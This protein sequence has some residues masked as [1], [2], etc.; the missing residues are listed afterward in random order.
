M[1]FKV[2]PWPTIDLIIPSDWTGTLE[3]INPGNSA[4]QVNN[5][6]TKESQLAAP[7]IVVPFNSRSTVLG[8]LNTIVDKPSVVSVPN[9]KISASDALS[10]VYFLGVRG[11]TFK[12][13]SV[14]AITGMF[15]GRAISFAKSSS[16]SIS[17]PQGDVVLN[18]QN[19]ISTDLVSLYS[20]TAPVVLDVFPIQQP[21]AG[22][23]FNITLMIMN[24]RN[25]D[26]N[27]DLF[28]TLKEISPA[29]PIQACKWVS[30]EGFD[31]SY[32]RSFSSFLNNFNSLGYSTPLEYKFSCSTRFFE[33][34]TDPFV[35]NIVLHYFAG[36]IPLPYVFQLNVGIINSVVT[37]SN[38]FVTATNTSALPI[39]SA[40]PNH[41]C[42]VGA[43]APNSQ[44]TVTTSGFK[45]SSETTVIDANRTI[46]M[47]LSSSVDPQLPMTKFSCRAAR[48]LSVGSYPYSNGNVPSPQT[49]LGCKPD[50]KPFKPQI[51]HSKYTLNLRL[52]R[53][54]SDNVS[55]LHGIHLSKLYCKQRQTSRSVSRSQNFR[56][57]PT[58]HRL[59]CTTS[60]KRHFRLPHNQR[61]WIWGKSP[62][63]QFR[64]V[65]LSVIHL[66]CF[67]ASS[68][69]R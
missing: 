39:P 45:P 69:L 41:L 52:N 16:V 8:R 10:P 20:A 42:A 26:T 56:S 19:P 51:L 18:T 68:S 35:Y 4:L 57:R 50:H 32:I 60:S 9:L 15:I 66:C 22:S 44:N 59:F 6:E 64:I 25:L 21:A 46:L 1:C 2:Y 48:S 11:G 24:V 13:I 67:R 49:L 58:E 3:L 43:L 27:Q 34:S 36:S 30:F 62:R 63:K 47:S 37:L 17:I 28:I 33:P 53:K 54:I 7:L 23:T 31:L 14:N 5:P 40:S 38:L 55:A 29:A 61:F 12:S 65:L